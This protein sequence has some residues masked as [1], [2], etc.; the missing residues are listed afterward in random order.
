MNREAAG[1]IS[2]HK[3]TGPAM[4]LLV[5][6]ISSDCRGQQMFITHTFQQFYYKAAK[7]RRTFKNLVSFS[8]CRQKMLH[9]WKN[10]F[11]RAF[12]ESAFLLERRNHIISSL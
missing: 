4:K 2:T 1:V 12:S 6:I 11:P 9:C 10:F 7:R 8:T 5:K 3:A